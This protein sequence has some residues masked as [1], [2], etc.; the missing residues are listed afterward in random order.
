MNW[1]PAGTA[2]PA[3][4]KITSDGIIY[5]REIL[6]FV[7]SRQSSDSQC[8][9]FSPS[10]IF[11]INLISPSASITNHQIHVKYDVRSIKLPDSMIQSQLSEWKRS[12]GTTVLDQL[13]ALDNSEYDAL[14]ATENHSEKTL[15]WIQFGEYRTILQGIGIGHL[16][17]RTLTVIMSG[18]PR[19]TSLFEK[20]RKEWKREEKKREDEEEERV[21]WIKV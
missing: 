21:T 2:I 6:T 8:Q 11:S 17:A 4:G 13:A 20:K 9:I 3:K 7:S 10:R 16:K 18:V 1:V 5:T 15:E 19:P 14:D 12:L